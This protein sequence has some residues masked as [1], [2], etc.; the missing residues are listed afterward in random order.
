MDRRAEAAARAEAL[1]MRTL[2]ERI[3]H[4]EPVPGISGLL[5]RRIRATTKD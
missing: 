3:E 5:H 4:D 2:A 1:A